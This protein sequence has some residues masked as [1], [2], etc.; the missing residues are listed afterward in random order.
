[1]TNK[2]GTTMTNATAREAT[3][4]AFDAIRVAQEAVH[5]AYLAADEHEM[6]SL[7]VTSNHL[8]QALCALPL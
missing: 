1:M 4:T 8:T 2:G 3:H 7:V 5:A 6:L